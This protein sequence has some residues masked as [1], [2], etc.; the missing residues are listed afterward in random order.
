MRRALSDAHSLSSA[1]ELASMARAGLELG[2]GGDGSVS[3]GM[4]AAAVLALQPQHMRV[5]TS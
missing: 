2:G 5:G 3:G 1:G 4:S